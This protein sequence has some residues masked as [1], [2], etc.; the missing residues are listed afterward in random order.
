M[1]LNSFSYYIGLA[2][3][4]IS[5]INR[6][7][8]LYK[9]DLYK[10]TLSHR[11]IFYPN[12]KL[13]YFNPISFIF[14]LDV[15]DV[16]EYIKVMFFKNEDALL[17]L[18]TYLKITKLSNYSYHML[19]ARLLYPS[20]YFDIYENIMNNNELEENL[21]PIIKKVE[22]YELFL[23]NSYLEISKYTEIDKIEWIIKKEL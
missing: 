1:I 5:Y 11:R 23:K 8:E 19:Y 16:A 18:I 6:A 22:E 10:V 12:T 4:A 3:N 20:Y 14:D 2:E 21:L 9:N 15:R 17:E 7:N 13:N